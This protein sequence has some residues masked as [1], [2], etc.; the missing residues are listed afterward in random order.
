MQVKILIGAEAAYAC[1]NTQFHK[2]DVKLDPGRPPWAS[3][4]STADE[5]RQQAAKLQQRAML[6]EEASYV[7]ES[8]QQS[9]YK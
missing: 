6:M 3:L 4:R 8:E 1:I 9:K 5:M 2:L 7:L